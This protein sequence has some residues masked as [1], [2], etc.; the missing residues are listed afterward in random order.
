MPYYQVNKKEFQNFSNQYV[1]ENA[2]IPLQVMSDIDYQIIS[3][4]LKKNNRNKIKTNDEAVSLTQIFTTLQS[5]FKYDSDM[6]K[7]FTSDNHPGK[8]LLEKMY[9]KKAQDISFEERFFDVNHNDLLSLIR[10]VSQEFPHKINR[11]FDAA[12]LITNTQIS[13]QSKID[14]FYH[15]IAMVD[16]T[17]QSYIIPVNFGTDSS[18]PLDPTLDIDGLCQI[19]ALNF[20]HNL[21]TVV[22]QSD[23]P[24]HLIKDLLPSVT[25]SSEQDIQKVHNNHLTQNFFD[26]S[27]LLPQII[28]NEKHLSN[29]IIQEETTIESILQ[30][31][32]NFSIEDVFNTFAKSLNSTNVFKSHIDA[33]SVIL[34]ELSKTN[35]NEIETAYFQALRYTFDQI[36]S[37]NA[38]SI[39]TLN[40]IDLN[41]DLGNSLLTNFKENYKE[42]ILNHLNLVESTYL[43]F[44]KNDNIYTIRNYK[45]SDSKNFS[46]ENFNNGQSFSLEQI[47]NNAPEAYLYFSQLVEKVTANDKDIYQQFSN[48]NIF[49]SLQQDIYPFLAYKDKIKYAN[50]SCFHQPFSDNKIEHLS[51]IPAILFED[52]QLITT[53]LHKLTETH[54]YD[55]IN[56]D[57]YIAKILSQNLQSYIESETSKT[58]NFKALELSPEYANKYSIQQL[59]FS[60]LHKNGEL[61]SFFENAF[62]L[63]EKHGYPRNHNLCGYPRNH[64]L[65]GYLENISSYICKSTESKELPSI[66]SF[67]NILKIK[68]RYAHREKFSHIYFANIIC[69]YPE[70]DIQNNNHKAFLLSEYF[71]K[72]SSLTKQSH[73]KY[74]AFARTPEFISKVIEHKIDNE[75]FNSL[76]TFEIP[77]KNKHSS[78]PILTENS[79]KKLNHLGL[80]IMHASIS[81]LSILPNEVFHDCESWK[82]KLRQLTNTHISRIPEELFNHVPEQ[83]FDFKFYKETLTNFLLSP[84]TAYEDDLN[85][86]LFH[87]FPHTYIS[88]PESLLAIL[89]KMSDN[90]DNSLYNSNSNILSNI[91]IINNKLYSTL[92][93]VSDESS[94][95][96]T[97]LFKSMITL[98]ENKMLEDYNRLEQSEFL[99][100]TLSKTTI[101]RKF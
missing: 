84:T 76:D 95:N 38:K 44:T 67:E 75:I 93:T 47:K 43:T 3:K 40:L 98:L 81:L 57:A 1:S 8:E 18:I 26:L 10:L 23:S 53:I 87:Q 73:A 88:K 99:N 49:N 37:S 41:S 52:N 61:N 27:S 11:H 21:N 4:H 86:Q 25:I 55:A 59:L 54:K 16:N 82:I 39:N 45:I 71:S 96:K 12:E 91:E 70:F 100:N 42:R 65:C 6:Q 79:L 66:I 35:P 78:Y 94:K 28:N 63:L 50:Y 36:Y 22:F 29:N 56:A 20:M 97:N 90:Q 64:N 13:N 92:K 85:K 24:I 72:T 62:S 48:S 32:S 34:I 7:A 89:K 68:E 69:D 15:V 19:Y 77:S 51:T 14:N 58:D 9:E 74:K 60:T 83:V 33:I 46:V 80:D 2:V 17:E 31:P 30:N 101:T 5:S